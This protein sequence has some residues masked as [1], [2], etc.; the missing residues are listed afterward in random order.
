MNIFIIVY[1]NKDRKLVFAFWPLMTQS[2]KIDVSHSKHYNSLILVNC[3]YQLKYIQLGLSLLIL[4]Q[5]FFNAY[6]VWDVIKG[7]QLLYH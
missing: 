7:R 4:D 2:W 5:Y 1:N 6:K 3:I